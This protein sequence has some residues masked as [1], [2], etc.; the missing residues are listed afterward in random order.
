MEIFLWAAVVQV[1][2]RALTASLTEIVSMNVLPKLSCLHVSERAS[3]CCFPSQMYLQTKKTGNA[4]ISWTWV[5]QHWFG[6]H[7]I[8]WSPCCHVDIN[9]LFYLHFMFCWLFLYDKIK[10]KLHRRQTEQLG[11][12]SFF[13]SGLLNFECVSQSCLMLYRKTPTSTFEG[14]LLPAEWQVF[15]FVFEFWFLCKK[16]LPS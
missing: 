16:K 2:S 14:R 11:S 12:S 3:C 13:C 15:V 5:S 10:M 6:H 4:S 8:F 9:P 7:L 1:N